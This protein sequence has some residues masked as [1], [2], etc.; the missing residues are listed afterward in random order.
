MRMCLG[1]IYGDLSFIKFDAYVSLYGG[2]A[3]GETLL[4]A[5]VKGTHFNARAAMLHMQVH[6]NVKLLSYLIDRFSLIGSYKR[7][8]FS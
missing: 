5:L 1:F 3:S 6:L 2:K 7:S 4:D 8:I